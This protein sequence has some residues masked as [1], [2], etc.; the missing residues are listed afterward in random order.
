MYLTRNFDQKFEKLLLFFPSQTKRHTFVNQIPRLIFKN[1][2][3]CKLNN[4]ISKNHQ[5]QD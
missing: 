2:V 5:I 3:S 4:A 1:L